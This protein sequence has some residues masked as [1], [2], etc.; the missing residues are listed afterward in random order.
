MNQWAALAEA[1]VRCADAFQDAWNAISE[2]MEQ[3]AEAISD[4]VST[5]GAFT[6]KIAPRCRFCGKGL[7]LSRWFVCECCGGPP[8]WWT[9]EI[10]RLL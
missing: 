3:L 2:C 4:I 1:M 7:S 9:P 10:V 8:R 6:R 5:L